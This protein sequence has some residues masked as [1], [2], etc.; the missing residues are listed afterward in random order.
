VDI[1]ATRRCIR[2]TI[3]PPP[4]QLSLHRRSAL[5]SH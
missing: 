4:P 3:C 2:N 1:I 5:S